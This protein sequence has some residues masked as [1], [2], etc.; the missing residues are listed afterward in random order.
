MQQYKN[1]NMICISLYLLLL[2][3]YCYYLTN[4]ISLFEYA[5]RN[6]NQIIS[7][8]SIIPKTSTYKYNYYFLLFIFLIRNVHTHHLFQEDLIFRCVAKLKVQ[9]NIPYF[10]TYLKEITFI[11]TFIKR[12]FNLIP[13][14]DYAQRRLRNPQNS[15]IEAYLFTYP[16][17]FLLYQFWAL[18][19]RSLI[20]KAATRPS[21]LV[22]ISK[23]NPEFMHLGFQATPTL[24]CKIQACKH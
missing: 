24:K 22:S 11:K 5:Q 17:I 10:I 14:V 1:A 16:I 23:R 19:P 12:S 2:L 15:S 6:E 18:Q 8:G 3:F 21:I 13:L 4:L 20:S 7:K 9:S